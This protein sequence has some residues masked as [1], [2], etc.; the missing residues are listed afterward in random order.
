[1][2]AAESRMV[3]VVVATSLEPTMA[4]MVADPGCVPVCRVEVAMPLAFVVGVLGAR[5][6]SVVVRI[7]EVPAETGL[8]SAFRAIAVTVAVLFTGTL[9]GDTLR[10]TVGLEPDAMPTWM[11]TYA[12]SEPEVEPVPSEVVVPPLP[13]PV[14]VAAVMVAVPGM[15]LD[16]KV[17]VALPSRSVNTIAGTE[18]LVALRRISVPG[19]NGWPS[20]LRPITVIVEVPFKAICV[21]LAEMAR[22]QPPCATCVPLSQPTTAMTEINERTARMD[23]RSAAARCIIVPSIRTGAAIRLDGRPGSESKENSTY[24]T[25][26]SPPE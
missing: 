14:P 15:P 25:A 13:L 7:T 23:S 10:I 3:N 24:L 5:V 21:G 18:P 2:F 11:V 17:A 9:L 19:F 26:R 4:L 12:D 22:M 1:M 6:P 16:L 8:P 20:G